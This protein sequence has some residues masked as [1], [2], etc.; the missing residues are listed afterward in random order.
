MG[1]TVVS[2]WTTSDI[3][4]GNTSIS[5]SR[6]NLWHPSVV[7]ALIA[8]VSAPVVFLRPLSPS[9][10]SNELNPSIE[11]PILVGITRYAL[12]MP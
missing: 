6:S 3:Y 4:K 11:A 5:V 12:T 9:S 8:V 10:T 7:V 2:N 1:F